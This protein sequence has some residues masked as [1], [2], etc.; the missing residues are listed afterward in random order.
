MGL[1][2]DTVR[3]E[4]HAALGAQVVVDVVLDERL[5]ELHFARSRT[6]VRIN[7]ERV[8]QL[9]L[10]VEPQAIVE[11]V[12]DEQDEPVEI[13]FVRVVRR[14][15]SVQIVVM[16]L[17]IAADMGA[18]GPARRAG[19]VTFLDC[20]N[21]GFGFL[22]RLIRF[23]PCFLQHLPDLRHLLFQLLEP[24][25]QLFLRGIRERRGRSRQAGE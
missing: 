13:D 21:S 4:E 18:L 11:F 22:V 25:L 16:K 5:L 12:A 2:Q 19:P 17:P 1:V 8:L 7:G 24:V 14:I 20:H 15:I 3:Q 23:L 9:E 10:T 6:V